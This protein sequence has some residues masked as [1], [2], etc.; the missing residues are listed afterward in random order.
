MHA[1]LRRAGGALDAV[2]QCGTN[3]SFSQVSESLEPRV[4]I[5]LLGINAVI[6]W[7]ALRTSGIRGP[8][9]GGGRLLRDH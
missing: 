9:L 7:H 8:V 1:L 5:P 6:L 2:V 4:G 3:M